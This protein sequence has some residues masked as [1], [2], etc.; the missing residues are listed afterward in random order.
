MPEKFD[1]HVFLQGRN[2]KHTHFKNG[3]EMGFQPGIP[4]SVRSGLVVAVLFCCFEFRSGPVVGHFCP[5]R[6]GSRTSGL[7][8]LSIS[9][10]VRLKNIPGTK[11]SDSYKVDTA[12]YPQ[13]FESW[14]RQ[15]HDCPRGPRRGARGAQGAHG[16]GSSYK[17]ES[18]VHI[19]FDHR[20]GEDRPYGRSSP[21]L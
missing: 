9:S 11:Y 3:S 2:K 4:G 17:V 13:A 18:K 15:E 19:R 20:Y 21:Y 12:L 10:P 16:R 6:S 8:K 7:Q 14:R 1:F 5:V